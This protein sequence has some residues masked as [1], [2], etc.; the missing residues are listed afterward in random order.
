MFFARPAT[1][2]SISRIF[3][4]TRP[5]AFRAVVV[6]ALMTL[7]GWVGWGGVITYGAQVTCLLLDTVSRRPSLELYVP[8]RVSSNLANYNW[9]AEGSKTMYN[10][11]LRAIVRCSLLR[12][13][14]C[15]GMFER[16]ER[17]AEV[18]ATLRHAKNKG[19]LN[20]ERWRC[21]HKYQLRRN[22]CGCLYEAMALLFHVQKS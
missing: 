16:L 5:T 19:G 15:L 10:S 11:V 20:S 18:A 8:Q 9:S 12:M 17:R 21:S 22:T 7:V 13:F 1:A 6:G 4:R 3:I 2:R 14:S